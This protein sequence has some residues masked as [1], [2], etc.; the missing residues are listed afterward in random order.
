MVLVVVRHTVAVSSHWHLFNMWWIANPLDLHRIENRVSTV[1]VERCHIDRAENAII[2]INKERTV[3]VPAALIGAVLLGP[4]TRITHGAVRLLGDSGTS[5]CW[6]GENGVRMY[7]SGHGLSRG[8]ELVMR[9]AYL[10]TRTSERL[11]VARAMYA[12]RFPE[13][14]AVETATMQQ[15]RGREGTRM[16]RVYRQHAQRTGLKWKG[17]QYRVG[18]PD[19]VGDDV[20]RLLSMGNSCLYGACHAAIVG[21]GASPALGF[22]HTGKSLSFVLDIADL[23]K[24]EYTIPLAFDLTLQGHIEEADIRHALRERFADGKFM[25]RVVRDI[26]SLLLGDIQSIPEGEVNHLWDEKGR[27]VLGGANY[28]LSV[29]D[30]DTRP[31]M[32]DGYLSI[33]GPEISEQVDW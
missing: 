7:A 8:S 5:M 28:S 18:D 6:V 16:K 19:A 11:K 3:R 1:Y 33:I 10:V 22:I 13:D 29:D 17:R 25:Q 9:Q 23:Y 26:C 24:A 32:E 14:E 27:T 15:L 30:G 4:G 21:V 31:L 20:N 2:F 12:M